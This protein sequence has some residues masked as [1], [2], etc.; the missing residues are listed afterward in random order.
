LAAVWLAGLTALG[1]RMFSRAY[2]DHLFQATPNAPAFHT[3]AY[4][5]DTLL[6][7][8]DLGQE[9]AWIASGW[10]LY[11]SWAL[12]GAGWILTTAVVAGLTGIFKRD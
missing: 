3:V 11:W 10:A 7:I 4:T 8:M 12:I 9:K 1:V 2:A 5:L 6:P